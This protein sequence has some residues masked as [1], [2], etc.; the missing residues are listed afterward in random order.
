MQQEQLE[1][2]THPHSSLSELAAEIRAG[3]AHADSLAQRAGTRIAA[4]GTSPLPVTPH[5]TRNDRYEAMMDMFGMMA[6]EQLT[7][8]CHIHVSVSSDEEGVGALDRIRGWLAPLIALSTNSP[9]W[10]G[11]DSHY[12]SFRTQAWNRWPTAGPTGVFGS[13]EAYHDLMADLLGTGVV[14]S[15]DFDARLSRNYPTVEVRV[16]DVCLNSDDTV[17]LAALVRAL[18]E[19][20]RGNGML[21]TRRT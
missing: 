4:L 19:T 16:A 21:A 3:R 5:A 13:A 2:A 12:A 20:S 9:F 6:R 15:P 17:L 7:C 11:E 1:A 14:T 18:V 8:G 10:D